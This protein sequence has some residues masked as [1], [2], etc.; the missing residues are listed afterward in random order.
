MKTTPYAAAARRRF[1][2][3]TRLLGLF[4]RRYTRPMAPKKKSVAFPVDGVQCS[5][6]L[7]S[8]IVIVGSGL[9][10]NDERDAFKLPVT[11]PL[12]PHEQ[13]KAYVSERV[14]IR[15]KFAGLAARAAAAS[16]SA[17]S[18]IQEDAGTGLCC[19]PRTV[20]P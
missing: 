14:R 10:G 7:K 20:E 11:V 12:E 3:Y 18:D 6:D 2:I 5:V 17:S 9:V 13:L 8:R 15:P 4:R 19:L 16:S 1:S